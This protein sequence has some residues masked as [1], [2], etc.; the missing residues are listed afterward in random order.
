MFLSGHP[1]ENYTTGYSFR[2]IITAP[3]YGA[4]YGWGS[5]QAMSVDRLAYETT[6]HR[7]SDIG[8]I[9]VTVGAGDDP[10]NSTGERA[11]VLAMLNVGDNDENGSSGT[12][13]YATS[14]YIPSGFQSP[15][16]WG[17]VMQLHGPNSYTGAA[18]SPSFAFDIINGRYKLNQ[19][20]GDK[21]SPTYCN[22]D[23]GAIVYD[24]WVDFVFKV[25]WASDN[26][27][28]T[29][30]WT[31]VV[32]P[33]AV[34]EQKLVDT[35]NNGSTLTEWN[36]PTLYHNGSGT[37]EGH[38]WKKGLYRSEESFTNILYLGMTSRA[39]NFHDAVLGAFGNYLYP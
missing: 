28:A 25:T 13:Y 29:A 31:R 30:V 11:E 8:C 37:I 14:V 24:Q 5:I 16:L 19:R 38:Y 21:N 34:L 18:A 36:T 4:K 1:I 9:K 6:I 17:I 20:G 2:D 12:K 32:K 39:D 33:G 15:S 3:S 27:G 22:T 35:N 23:L 10:I 26:T 7:R